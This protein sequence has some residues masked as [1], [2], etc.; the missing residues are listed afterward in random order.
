[1][2]ATSDG[3]FVGDRRRSTLGRRKGLQSPHSWVQIP[4]SPPEQG[5]SLEGV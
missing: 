5:A 1:M 4:P 2:T 3:L